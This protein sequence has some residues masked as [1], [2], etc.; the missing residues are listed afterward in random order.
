M[1]ERKKKT[2]S[3]LSHRET[4]LSLLPR[5]LNINKKLSLSIL[6]LITFYL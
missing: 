1:K 6:T 4:A 5:K 3:F 2:F